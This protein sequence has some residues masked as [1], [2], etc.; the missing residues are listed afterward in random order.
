TW[1]ADGGTSSEQSY[2][3]V[4]FYVTSRGY[5]VLVDSPDEV[6]FEV[7]SE[8]N[9]RVQFSVSGETLDYFVIG[10][11][12]PMAVLR[13]YTALTGRPP[14]EPAWSFG[15]WLTTSLTANYDEAS[16]NEFIDGFAERDLPLSVFHFD[17]FWMR[18][19]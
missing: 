9:S 3:A 15:L 1:N 5:G 10:G 6:S 18:E 7:G 4:P 12:S 16:V 19:Y 8:V 13:R 11:G 2:K 14:G 17:S